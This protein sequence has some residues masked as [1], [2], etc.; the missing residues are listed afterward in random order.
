MGGGGTLPPMPARYLQTADIA[1]MHGTSPRVVQRL[2]Q[3]RGVAPAM[4]VGKSYLW[5][6]AQAR[7]LKPGPR[8][9]PK[10]PAPKRRRR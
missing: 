5:T 1:K 4:V 6:P 2:A 9:R 8:G 10:K 3:T 7:K